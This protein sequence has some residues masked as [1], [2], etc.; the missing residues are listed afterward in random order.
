MASL[1]NGKVQPGGLRQHRKQSDQCRAVAK[2]GTWMAN[3][4]ETPAHERLRPGQ[5]VDHHSPTPSRTKKLYGRVERIA[6]ASGSQFALFAARQC[7]PA[8]SPKWS[9]ASRFASS[10]TRGQPLLERLLPG[11][12]VEE[13]TRIHTDEAGEPMAES[14]DGRPGARSRVAASDLNPCSRVLVPCC[15][16]RFLANFDSRLTTVGLPDLRG[17][18]FAGFLT[19]AGLALNG[20]DRLADIHRAPRWP[21]S[22]PHSACA[23]S[24]AIPSLGLRAGSRW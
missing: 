18:F 5:P 9:S 17:A 22:R 19:R 16:A 20:V 2:C 1:V 12:S 8:I 23:A 14:S 3:Y 6:P 21:G 11:M 13:K 15:S 7:P 24:W 4:K 10:S